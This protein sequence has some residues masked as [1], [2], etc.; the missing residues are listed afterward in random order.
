MHEVLN[1][2]EIKKL[3]A[4]FYRTLRD[5]H[6]ESNLSFFGHFF[7]KKQKLLQCSDKNT[8]ATFPESG[9]PT[10]DLNTA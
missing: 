10:L 9:D 7:T 4:Q 8:V 2:D 5:E 1:V 6:F 3:I